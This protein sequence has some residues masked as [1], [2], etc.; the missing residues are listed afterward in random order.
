ML[1]PD[2]RFFTPSWP[3]WT[4]GGGKKMRRKVMLLWLGLICFAYRAGSQ[5]MGDTSPEPRLERARLEQNKALVR[6]WIAEGFNRKNL[7]VVDEVFA[8]G[9]V[10]NGQQIGRGGLRKSMSR[11]LTGFPDLHVTITDVVAEGEKVAI[12]YTVERT[13]R[14]EFDG[15]RPT[16]K[17]VSWTGVDLFRIGGG[18]IVEARFLS[19]ALGLLRQLGAAPPA[20]PT[21]K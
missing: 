3:F 4:N 13:H 12:W 7:N 14:G 16:G 6:R 11:H 9:I 21:R 5:P 8:E 1:R 17:Q 15:I 19:D 10:V 18:K 2:P 20:S